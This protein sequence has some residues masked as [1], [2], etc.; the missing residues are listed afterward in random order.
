M[1]TNKTECTTCGHNRV[2]GIKKRFSSFRDKVEISIESGGGL[3]EDRNNFVATI[4]CRQWFPDLI[5][6]NCFK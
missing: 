2:C 4:E 1:F 6:D 5:P 3:I